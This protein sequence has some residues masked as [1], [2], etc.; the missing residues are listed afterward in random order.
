MDSCEPRAEME[1]LTDEE[2]SA[3]ELRWYEGRMLPFSEWLLAFVDRHREEILRMA[4]ER[5]D[6][7]NLLAAVNELIIRRG[8]MHMAKEMED[9]KKEIENELWYRGEKGPCDRAGVQLEWTSRHAAAWRRWRIR[10]YL[11]VVDRCAGLVVARLLEPRNE[12]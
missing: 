10:E 3:L 7:E 4:A 5:T 12:R 9:Q 1:P 11:F 8:S 6:P 2:R